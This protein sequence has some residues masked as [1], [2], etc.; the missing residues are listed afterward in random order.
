MP[1]YTYANGKNVTYNSE[2]CLVLLPR[3]VDGAAAYLLKKISDG[4]AMDNV[5]ETDCS[6]CDCVALIDSIWPN[7]SYNGNNGTA[8][9]WIMNN[10]IKYLC[11]TG[12]LNMGPNADNSVYTF[13]VNDGANVWTKNKA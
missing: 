4:A 10:L 13:S 7:F 5:L 3:E 12:K 6:A 8:S 11:D 2:H 1:T 9:N